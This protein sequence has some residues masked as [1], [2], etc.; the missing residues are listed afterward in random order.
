MLRFLILSEVTKKPE[1]T[2]PTV[3]CRDKATSLNFRLEKGLILTPQFLMEFLEKL[4]VTNSFHF[5]YRDE[6][7]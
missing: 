3:R 7:T 4:T 5:I 2:Y 6:K 1:K